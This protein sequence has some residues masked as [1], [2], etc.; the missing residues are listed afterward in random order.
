[1]RRLLPPTNGEPARRPTLIIAP[2]TTLNNWARELTKFTFLEVYSAYGEKV[3]RATPMNDGIWGKFAQGS[4]RAGR[5]VILT[6]SNIITIE[7]HVQPYAHAPGGSGQ[8]GKSIFRR[9]VIDES[10]RIFRRA[11]SRAHNFVRDLEVTCWFLTGTPMPF[12]PRDLLG[13][14]EMLQYED[15][16]GEEH[17]YNCISTDRFLSDIVLPWERLS[18]KVARL[19]HPAEKYNSTSP[20]KRQSDPGTKQG[21]I[22]DELNQHYQGLRLAAHS[23]A[24]RLRLF[25]LRRTCN[26]KM[27]GKPLVDLPPTTHVDVRLAWVTTADLDY[28]SKYQKE[29]EKVLA[30]VDRQY[31]LT[32]SRWQK[33]GQKGEPPTRERVTFKLLRRLRACASIP[34]LLDYD[35]ELAL[36]EY[37]KGFLAGSRRCPFTPN[38]EAI[39]QSSRKLQWVEKFIQNLGTDGEGRPEKLLIF[40]A[41]PITAYICYLV[42]TGTATREQNKS[43]AN[44][45]RSLNGLG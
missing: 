17:P 14:V 29:R 44:I 2:A 8:P 22:E 40:T 18:S 24:D 11:E 1:M 38:L 43:S 27:W 26:T 28:R 45:I 7:R 32:Y 42:S 20:S 6:S 39:L 12:G 9:V 37:I 5:S 3:E 34:A 4:K 23:L 19:M 31:L 25:M 30:E 41:Q 21:S 35:N 15:W 33:A 10:H 16:V 13:L 36:S